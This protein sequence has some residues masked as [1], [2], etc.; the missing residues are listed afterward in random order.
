[1]SITASC[2][3]HDALARRG[4][5][6]STV[7][8]GGALTPISST[9]RLSSLLTGSMI[10]A[11]ASCPEPLSPPADRS[12]PRSSRACTRTSHRCPIRDNVTGSGRRPAPHLVG[13]MRPRA[14]VEFAPHQRPDA[15]ARR[16]PRPPARPHPRL[17]RGARYPA[18]PRREEYTIC[19]AVAR[20]THACPEPPQQ[21]HAKNAETTETAVAAAGLLLVAVW[22]PAIGHR[23][24]GRPDVPGTGPA[25]WRRSRSS[26]GTSVPGLAAKPI[27]DLMAATG[28][29]DGVGA[30]EGNLHLL[31]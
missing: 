20:H 14:Q 26:A 30:R 3:R 10:R 24:G 18:T 5:R 6:R 15:G 29:L 4:R 16:P 25:R 7:R 9:R 13:S 27:I 23:A 12:K 8:Y 17:A 28:D 31:G 2:R 1:M 11:S 21:T 19:A 22:A